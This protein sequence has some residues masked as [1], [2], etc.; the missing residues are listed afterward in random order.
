MLT[1]RENR[2]HDR[3]VDKCLVGLLQLM[4]KCINVFNDKDITKKSGDILVPF[5]S[6]C[7]FTIPSASNNGLCAPPKVKSSAT[8]HLLLTLS[9]NPANLHL[10]LGL[11]LENH[12]AIKEP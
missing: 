9:N 1:I 2:R 4:D 10:L 6:Q 5:L 3:P 8:T 11:L 12:F 7:L